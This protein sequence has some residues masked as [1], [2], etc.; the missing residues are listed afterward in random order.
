VR[1]ATADADTGGR[2]DLSLSE[3]QTEPLPYSASWLNIPV[4]IPILF[5][6][7]RDTWTVREAIAA[8]FVSSGLTG[9]AARVREP[10]QERFGRFGVSLR[11]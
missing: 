8:G 7:G 5:L 6:R 11:L 10:L 3:K 1:S 2:Y 4:K 9:Y